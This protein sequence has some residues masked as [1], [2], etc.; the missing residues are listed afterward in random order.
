[1]RL[2]GRMGE[3]LAGVEILDADAPIAIGNELHVSSFFGIRG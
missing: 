1:M 3:Q 2:P